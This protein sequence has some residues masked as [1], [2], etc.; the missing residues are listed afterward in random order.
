MPGFLAE[1]L[2]LPENRW[3][4]TPLKAAY[5]TGVPPTVL[6]LPDRK[7]STKWTRIDKLLLLAWQTYQDDLCKKCGVPV[8]L[9]HSEDPNI[10][11]KIKKTVCYSCQHLEHDKEEPPAGGTKYTVPV[12]T[13]VEGE[14]PKPL[15]T[16]AEG[17]ETSQ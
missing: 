5:A 8:W 9:G 14:E 15:P 11:F 2:Y 1:R 13:E 4:H 17:F 7:S 3:I 6:I 16:R 10:D 12:P